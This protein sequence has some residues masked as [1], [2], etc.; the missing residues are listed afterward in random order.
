MGRY[1]T[2][3][4]TARFAVDNDQANHKCPLITGGLFATESGDSPAQHQRE[5]TGGTIFDGA[6]IFPRTGAVHC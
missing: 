4:L 1:P 5:T 3:K 2:G 6:A